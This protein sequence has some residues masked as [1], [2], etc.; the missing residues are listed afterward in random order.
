MH[1]RRLRNGDVGVPARDSLPRCCLSFAPSEFTF[2]KRRTI[3]GAKL[4]ASMNDRLICACR[5]KDPGRAGAFSDTGRSLFVQLAAQHASKAQKPGTKQSH[6]GG[7]GN[8][9]VTPT[10]YILRDSKCS[11]AI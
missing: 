8:R 10:V 4:P 6:R 11:V 7:L 9:C 5:K 1:Q 2:G 3:A